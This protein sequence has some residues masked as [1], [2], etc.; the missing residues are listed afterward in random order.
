MKT[1]SPAAMDE[2]TGC[3]CFALRKASRVVTQFYDRALRSHRL[4]V[5]QL[6]LLAAA[7]Q[8]GT[9]PLARLARALGMD[10]TTLLRNVRPLVRRGLLQVSQAADSRRTEIKTTASGKTLLGRIYPDWKRAQERAL[11]LLRGTDWTESLR[12]LEKGLRSPK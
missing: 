1:L 7:S 5:T 9:V 2:M 10:R 4:R 6:S 3:V 11:K 12:A 8:Q